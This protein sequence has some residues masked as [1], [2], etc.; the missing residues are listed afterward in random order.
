MPRL[1]GGLG[2]A[3]VAVAATQGAAGLP[4]GAFASLVPDL[5]PGSDRLS[6]LQQVARSIVEAGGGRR[7]VVLV[8][9]AHLLDESSAALT[10]LLAAHPQT[11]V[12][13][14]L[15]AGTATPAPVVA[16]WKDGLAERLDLGPLSQADVGKLLTRVLGGPV[17][18][19]AIHQLWQRTEGNVLFLRELVLAALGAETLRWEGGIWRLTALLPVSSRLVEILETRLAGVDAGAR[20]SLGLLSLGEPLG[21]ELFERL[22]RLTSN[23]SM[24]LA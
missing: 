3:S 10:H 20:A 8:D 18:R 23:R 16:L 11:F 22:R 1:A 13:A 15:R 19:A 5:A 21:V 2:C 24:P 14:T 17:D 12:I 6:V 4:F 7:V 9:D